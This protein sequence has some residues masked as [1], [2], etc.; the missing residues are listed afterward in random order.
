MATLGRS[1]GDRLVGGQEGA[2]LHFEIWWTALCKSK[3]VFLKDLMIILM[4]QETKAEEKLCLEGRYNF[5]NTPT[6]ED[7]RTSIN[8]PIKLGQG[9]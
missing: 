1:T 9:P 3:S 5:R 2:F 8:T 4:F 7:G 6:Q